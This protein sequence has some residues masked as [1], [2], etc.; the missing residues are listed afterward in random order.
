M[1]V[2]EGFDDGNPKIGSQNMTSIPTSLPECVTQSFPLNWTLTG[3]GVFSWSVFRFYRAS[4]FQTGPLDGSHPYALDLLYMR[5]LSA[6]QIV[7]TSVDEM[8]RL[9]PEYEADASAWGEALNAFIPDVGLGDRLVG[10]FEPGSGVAFFSGHK[11]LGQIKSVAFA[12]AFAAIWLD[13]K[14][15]SPSLRSALLGNNP[16][17]TL[18]VQS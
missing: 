5:N 12:D 15:Q 17:K 2:T 10:V 1:H 14:T 8:L 11:L 3:S 16:V 13:E 18:A 9:R 7:Q 4:L 6:Q